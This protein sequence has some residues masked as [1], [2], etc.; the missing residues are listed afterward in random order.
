MLFSQYTVPH[1]SVLMLHAATVLLLPWQPA[2]LALQITIIDAEALGI[3]LVA[4]F[5][6]PLAELNWQKPAD[7]LCKRPTLV[8]L[9]VMAVSLQCIDIA[10]IATL[11]TRPW[12]DG[13]NGASQNVSFRCCDAPGQLTAR[14]MQI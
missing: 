14:V 7:R 4:C 10:A 2:V 6:P 13:G 12:F 9:F 1:R 11:A 8:L 3:G 5:V